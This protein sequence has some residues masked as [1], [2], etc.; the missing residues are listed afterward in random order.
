MSSNGQVPH[1]KTLD[2]TLTLIKEGYPFIKK[3]VERYQ[4]DL[5]E[6]R[7]LGQKVVCMS[8]EEAA[9][10]FYDRELFKRNGALPK[11]ILKSLF[12]ENAVQ[13]MDGDAHI[14]RKLLFVSLMTPPHQKRVA[15]LVMDEWQSAAEKWKGMEEVVLFEEAKE[16]LTRA[17]CKWAGIPLEEDEVKE[18]T[19]DFFEMVNAF[20]AFGPTHWKGRMAR[21]KTEEWIKRLIEDVRDGKLDAEKGSAIYE[22]AFHK[23]EDGSMLDAH[24]AGVE[25]IN[26]VRPL[27]AVCIF[28]AFS[29]AALYN[30][31]EYKENLR[32]GTETYFENFVQEVRRY[33]PFVPY[34]GAKVKK[35]FTWRDYTFEEEMLVLLD[36]YGTNHDSALWDEPNDFKPERFFTWAGGLFDLIPQ[37][38]GEASKGHRCPGEGITIEVMKTSL[39]FLVNKID[40]DVPE[41]DLSYNLDKMPTWPESGFVMKNVREK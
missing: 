7:L 2:N 33:Y 21:N 37:G 35:E 41:Q 10:K 20:G 32:S 9:K 31:P 8:G 40:Y 24:M 13:T 19:E 29:A 34:L 18:R 14:H 12:G 38:G 22:M 15:E 6:T 39:D 4:T 23:K 27:I 1:D 25:L 28:I 36:I 26:V 17:S 5:F 3:R 11:R 16:V 30:Y